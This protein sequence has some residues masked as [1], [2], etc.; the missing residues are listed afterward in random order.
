MNQGT[1]RAD[2]VRS[3]LSSFMVLLSTQLMLCAFIIHSPL[4]S[5]AVLENPTNA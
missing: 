1:K 2:L 4:F 3:P 5:F